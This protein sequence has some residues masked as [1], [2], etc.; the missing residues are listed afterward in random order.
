MIISLLS[1]TLRM[2]GARR[3]TGRHASSRGETA[4]EFRP[5]AAANSGLGLEMTAVARAP[6]LTPA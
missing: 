2:P 5:M 3:E 6:I 1:P 4:G